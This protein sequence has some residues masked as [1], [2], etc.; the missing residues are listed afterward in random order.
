MC[1]A[2]MY[3]ATMNAFNTAVSFTL[4]TFFTNLEQ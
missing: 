2:A 1:T 3:Q 4:N